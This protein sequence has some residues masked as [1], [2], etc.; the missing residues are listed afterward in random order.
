MA[1][2]KNLIKNTSYNFKL[3]SRPS[4]FIGIYIITTSLLID[5]VIVGFTTEASPFSFLTVNFLEFF[6][7]SISLLGITFSLLALFLGNRKHQR[8][9][10][11]KIWNKN[12]KKMMWFVFFAITVLYFI[13]FYL[14]RI[15]QETFIIPTFIISY[16]FLLILFNF[17]RIKVLYQFSMTSFIIGFLPLLIE[18]FSFQTLIIFGI[19]HLVFGFLNSISNEI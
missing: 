8:R 16:G 4:F 7:F 5:L 2:N 6:I 10:G 17:S 1:K 3:R 11:Y 12:S 19:S 15:G 14:L 18:N 13:E 9:I